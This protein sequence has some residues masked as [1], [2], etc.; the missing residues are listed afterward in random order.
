[1]IF[2]VNSWIM[3]LMV[4]REGNDHSNSG[5]DDDDDD[6]HVN[7]DVDGRMHSG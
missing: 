2:L 3:V 5:N 6:G 1:M 7:Q 4:G